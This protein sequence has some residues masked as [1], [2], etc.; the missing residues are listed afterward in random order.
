MGLSQDGDSGASK[1]WSS[2]GCIP[3]FSKVEATEFDDALN[4]GGKR[5]PPNG[6]SGYVIN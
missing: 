2:T 3:T 5:R 1:K 4:V 6:V